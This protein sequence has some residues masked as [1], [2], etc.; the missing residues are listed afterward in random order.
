MCVD[1]PCEL[2][3]FEGPG[4]VGMLVELISVVLLALTLPVASP[5]ISVAAARDAIIVSEWTWY[6]Y[7]FEILNGALAGKEPRRRSLQH[8]KKQ[9][10]KTSPTLIAV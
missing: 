10:R 4:G 3:V 7:H 2:L 9:K 5:R 6:R 8:E 1:G